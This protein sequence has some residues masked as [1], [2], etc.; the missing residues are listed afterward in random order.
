MVLHGW[1]PLPALIFRHGVTDGEGIRTK[2]TWFG[3]NICGNSDLY[4]T[5]RPGSQGWDWGFAEILLQAVKKRFLKASVHM[6]SVLLFSYSKIIFL[7]VRPPSAADLVGVSWA[8]GSRALWMFDPNSRNC[9]SGDH[10]PKMDIS[11][12]DQALTVSHRDCSVIFLY[13]GSH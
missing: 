10:L 12:G 3:N 11:C 1:L 6:C 2:V 4:P 8:N 9:A 7:A 5:T 13:R